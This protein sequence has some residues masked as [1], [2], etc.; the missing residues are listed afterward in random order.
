MSLE[1]VEKSVLASAEAEAKQ[2]LDEAGAE[3]EAELDR[4]SA[5]LRA[6]QRRQT[7]QARADADAGYE[8]DVNLRR[9]EHGMR[10]LEA[11]NAIIDAIFD[12]ARQRILASQGFDY[13]LWLAEQVRRACGKAS[14]TLHC[15]ERDRETVEAA[16]RDAGTHETRV[17]VDN[18]ID[19][20]V[21]LV[22]EG[23]DLDLTLGS[24]LADLRTELTV[25]LAERLFADLPALGETP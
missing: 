24:M 19:G 20:G 11:K 25:S 17:E 10:I 18:A 6:E 12:T 1:D 3:A 5:A 23:F 22:A 2:I 7:D 14:G 21:L 16:V 4:R 8:R 9:A 15:N 13:D